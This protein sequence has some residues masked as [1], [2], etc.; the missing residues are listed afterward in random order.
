MKYLSF[1]NNEVFWNAKNHSDAKE[2]VKQ[3]SVYAKMFEVTA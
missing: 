2:Y 3:F 1:D